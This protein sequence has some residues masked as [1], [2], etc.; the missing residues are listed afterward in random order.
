MPGRLSFLGQP[1]S[2]REPELVHCVALCLALEHARA[3]H[4]KDRAGVVG[5]DARVAGAVAERGPVAALALV[6]VVEAGQP[7][8]AAH[9]STHP[10]SV[11]KTA[12]SGWPPPPHCVAA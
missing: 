5:H 7:E 6:R 11:T 8:A 3:Q 2:S 4:R 12:A 10:I 9:S 1:N